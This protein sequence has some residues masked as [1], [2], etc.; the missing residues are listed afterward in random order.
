MKGFLSPRMRQRL[1]VVGLPAAWMGLF[2]V[3]PFLIVL[4]ISLS[5]M[6]FSQPPYTPLWDAAGAFQGHLNNYWRLIED[7]LYA[8]AYL[9]AVRLAALATALALVVGYPLAYGV[10][11]AAPHIRPLLLGAIILPFWTSLLVR[12]YAWMAILKEE[13]ILNQLLLNLGFI[14]QPLVILNTEYAVVLGMVYAYLPFMVLPLYAVIEKI[15]TSL[16]EAAADLGC[17]PV[18]AFWRVTVPLSVPGIVAGCLLVFIPAVGEFVIPDLMGGSST[19]LISK[20]IWADFFQ[21]R[22]WP[23]AAAV[24]IVLTLLLVVPI[25]VAQRLQAKAEAAR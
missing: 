7:G 22:D 14:D 8:W 11:R 3:L 18:R 21:N 15:D 20:V 16:L 4:R 5:D 17:R 25:V 24:T 2:F 13:G 9:D 1:F 6:E 10:S 23:A 12:V 19:M